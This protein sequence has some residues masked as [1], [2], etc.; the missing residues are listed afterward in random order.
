MKKTCISFILF[1]A[2]S[3]VAHATPLYPEAL[4]TEY[5]ENP[6]GIDVRTPLFGWQ[7]QSG[8]ERGQRQSAYEIRV[9]TAAD[10]LQQGKGILWK[11]GKVTS[12]QNTGI[13]YAGRR[14]QPF[15]RY[16]WQVRVYTPDGKASDWSR[17]A[18]WETAMLQ[19]TDWKAAWID[20]GSEAPEQTDDFYKEDPAPQFRKTFHTE[21]TVR[22]AR[23]YIAGL[24][25]YEASL[26]GT[27][28]GDQVLDPGWTN[29]GQQILYSTYD[30]TPLLQ[31]GVNSLGVVLGNGFYN[32]LPMRIFK[33]LREYLTIG[34]PCLKA[35]LRLTYTDGTTQTIG[36]D[37]SWKTAPGPILR[38]N[39]YLGE[40]YDARRE[41]RGWDTPTF[42]DSSWQTVSLVGKAPSGTLTAQMQPPIRVREVI[43]P[44]RMTESRPGV[45]VFDMGQNFAGVARL[46]LQGSKGTR[47]TL[48]YGEDVY[49]DG[50]L[51]VM[52][53]V[54]GQQKTIWNA[55][56][57][58]PGQPQTAWQEDSY[59]LK[60]EGE[61]TWA[62]RFTFH[63]FRYVEVTGWNGR[64]TLEN[65]EGLRL[66][67]DLQP[68]GTFECSNPMLN[69]LHQVMDY[70]FLSNVFSVQSD[71]PA[72]EKFGY[73]GDIVGVSRT[74]CWF[75]N[76]ENFYRKAI[77]DFAN[78]QRPLGG[79][80]E[81]APFNGIADQGLGDDSGP[82]GWQL[83]F[84]FM[85]KQL[86]EFYGD[87]RTI[88]DY[89]PTLV[90]QVEF[91]RSQAKENI[92]SQCINDHESLDERIPALFATA[93]Y[94]HHVLLLSEFADLTGRTKE[95]HTYA[96]LAAGIKASFIQNFLTPGTGRIGNHTQAAQ[97]IALVYDLVPESEKQAAFNVFLE[98]IAGKDGHITS[99]IFGIPAVLEVLRRNNRNDIAYEMVTKK[100]YPGWGH[101]LESGATTLWETWKYSDNTYSQNH[102]MFGSVG[103]W[104]YQSLAGINPAAAGFNKILIKP[105]PAGD[106]TWVNSSYQS[107]NGKI[108]S[109]WKREGDTFTLQVSIP[110]NTTAEVCIPS[111]PQ[112]VITESDHPADTAAGIKKTGYTHGFS[113]FEV[114]SGDYTFKV[115][116]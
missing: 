108:V 52:T 90:R 17:P 35:Q 4:T 68:T 11:S 49:S 85:Q 24:G 110:A 53:S 76:M 101:M 94:Y 113:S 69:K 82:V 103:E 9:A 66:S 48:R 29:F 36:T 102:P 115:V 26:N 6:L 27:R 10:N 42:D 37:N 67:A 98:A 92:I 58:A 89:Y 46:K 111:S 86:H 7:L 31:S 43:R 18:W 55:N 70:T 14:L 60:G 81:T 87:R 40:H 54:A 79:M 51:N 3:F 104:M 91:L 116:K 13:R 33:P 78:D 114:G 59:T 97:A 15:T 20:N 57:Q 19:P 39:A 100:D 64:P 45:F 63:G 2:F 109:N 112:S 38:N 28:I 99:G 96:Q 44:T 41:T 65:I 71:C 61:E 32:P 47:I 105:Q 25:Y 88:E 8:G 80:P 21:K 30:V 77:R 12:A 93:H 56:R 75:Y 72:R 83:A 5:T 84:A 73:G 16:Y 23:L 74:F 50:S 34:R 95:A 106:L 22:E 1:I 62:P 107:V